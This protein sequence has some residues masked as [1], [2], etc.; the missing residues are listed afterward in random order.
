MGELKDNISNLSNTGSIENVLI[1][2]AYWL[3]VIVVI[4]F[5]FYIAVKI[6]NWRLYSRRGKGEKDDYLL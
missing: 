2:I 3:A 6:N 4:L 1:A 5:V